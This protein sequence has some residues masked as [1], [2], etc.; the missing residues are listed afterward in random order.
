MQQ[1]R[2]QELS[3]F[4]CCPQATLSLVLC[5]IIEKWSFF[6]STAGSQEWAAAMLDRITRN[7]VRARQRGESE[8]WGNHWA[9]DKVRT[10]RWVTVVLGLPKTLLW[11]RRSPTGCIARINSLHVYKVNDEKWRGA[12]LLISSRFPLIM[13]SSSRPRVNH[14]SHRHRPK[15]KWIGAP[16]GKEILIVIKY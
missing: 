15:Y 11:L 12:L 7:P 3:S 10:R 16:W 8:V 14:L 1:W 9:W 4:G 6:F 2:Y 5:K 13:K